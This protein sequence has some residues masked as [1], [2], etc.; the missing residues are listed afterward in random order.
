[1]DLYYHNNI[2]ICYIILFDASFEWTSQIS[3]EWLYK[4]GVLRKWPEAWFVHLR[5]SVKFSW[6]TTRIIIIAV[7]LN[8]TKDL[9]YM[10]V[11]YV[12]GRWHD[13][14]IIIVYICRRAAHVYKIELNL[15]VRVGCGWSARAYGWPQD[16]D[17]RLA[18][19]DVCSLN[20]R[21]NWLIP[22]AKLANP[23]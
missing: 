21:N 8:T 9:L 17:G 22:S 7:L 3:N 19:R 16:A 18:G 2:I 4:S 6:K 11:V 12:R 14:I 10:S 23:G 20:L 15:C 1:M 13:H 5:G